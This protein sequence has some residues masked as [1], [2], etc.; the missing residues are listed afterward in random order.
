MEIQLSRYIGK[1]IDFYS[2]IYIYISNVN[3]DAIDAQQKQRNCSW[4]LNFSNHH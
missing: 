3:I 1:T 2:D 4:I